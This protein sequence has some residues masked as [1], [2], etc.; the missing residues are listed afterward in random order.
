MEPLPASGVRD[1]DTLH[2]RGAAELKPSGDAA[3]AREPPTSSSGVTYN[4][5]ERAV[6]VV[7]ER[8]QHQ[9]DVGLA[10]LNPIRGSDER[11]RSVASSGS[12]GWSTI[13]KSGKP[14][15]GR[16]KAKAK[17]AASTALHGHTSTSAVRKRSGPA[18]IIGT[19]TFI[20]CS[21]SDLLL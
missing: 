3:R 1:G 7:S 15:S 9:G 11:Q 4:K 17:A 5:R 21:S 13:V 19:G 8:D 18:P 16:L 14:V 12:P 20:I 10:D 6:N 2:E